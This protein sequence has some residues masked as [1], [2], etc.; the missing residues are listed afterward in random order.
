MYNLTAAAACHDDRE[1][2]GRLGHGARCTEKLLSPG[3]PKKRA[4]QTK[5]GCD[6]AR[7]VSRS[8]TTRRQSPVRARKE[9]SVEAMLLLLASASSSVT[10]NP[11]TLKRYTLNHGQDGEYINLRGFDLQTAETGKYCPVILI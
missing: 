3:T 6:V 9:P 2:V 7:T 8:C 1:H 5:D 4:L 11:C 10:L